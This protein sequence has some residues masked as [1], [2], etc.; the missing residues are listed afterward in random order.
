MMN[1]LGKITFFLY[2][3]ELIKRIKKATKEHQNEI[4]AKFD[5]LTTFKKEESDAEE[6]EKIRVAY[7]VNKEKVKVTRENAQL[8]ISYYESE[9]YP[10]LSDE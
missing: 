7:I 1:Q 6:V 2:D 3:I 5:V 4:D 9:Q 8:F 10:V